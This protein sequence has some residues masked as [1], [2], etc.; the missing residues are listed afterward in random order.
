MRPTVYREKASKF[1][2]INKKKKASS[3][4]RVSNHR[5]KHR[6]KNLTEQNL[7]K[8]QINRRS[9]ISS[10]WKEVRKEMNIFLISINKKI[11]NGK[12]TIF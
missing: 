11:G 6:E 3:A 2:D 7:F 12:S 8:R 9:N 10:F 4:G 5:K 1:M